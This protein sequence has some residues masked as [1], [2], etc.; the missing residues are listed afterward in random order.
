MRLSLRVFLGFFLIVGLAAFFLLNTFLQE[1]KPGVRQ[2]MEV[3]LVDTA[4]L[5]A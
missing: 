1:V 3:A 4:N 2:G 5:L